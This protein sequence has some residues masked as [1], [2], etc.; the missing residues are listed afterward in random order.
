MASCFISPISRYNNYL[1][2]TTTV[3]NNL[4]FLALIRLRQRHPGDNG[5]T[6]PEIIKPRT[7]RSKIQCC[8]LNCAFCH[9][10]KF[11]TVIVF[12]SF[13]QPLLHRDLAVLF[14]KPFDFFRCQPG[15][16]IR[17]QPLNQLIFLIWAPISRLDPA[18]AGMC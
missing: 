15:I 9:Y 12:C 17:C 18:T 11:W 2:N 5:I 16:L 4:P 10:I 8:C 1:F 13:R 6:L 3:Y 7:I 14:L